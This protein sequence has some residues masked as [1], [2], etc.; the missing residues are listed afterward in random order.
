MTD[1]AKRTLYK[2]PRKTELVVS[3]HEICE[4]YA[5]TD[6]NCTAASDRSPYLTCDIL[7]SAGIL[8]IMTWLIGLN[9]LFGNICVLCLRNKRRDRNSV[10]RVL[11]SNLAKSDLLMGVYML[12][13]GQFQ[14][15]VSVRIVCM[16]RKS[17][18]IWFLIMPYQSLLQ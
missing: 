13:I 11:L 14:I 7:L 3:Q 12:F 17:G 18:R 10:Q 15:T 6:I 4:C 1:I 9:A 16:K 8:M 5:P 2:L